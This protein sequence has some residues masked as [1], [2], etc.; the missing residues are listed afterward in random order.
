MKATVR[1]MVLVAILL[2]FGLPNRAVAQ[3]GTIPVG[4]V[5]T[6]QNWQ[7]Y[8]QF[9]PH[10][11]QELAK[12]TYFWKLPPDF[13]LVV[14]PTHHYAPP[15]TFQQY[16][17]KY[18]GLVKIGD[19]P[20]GKHL[21][22][23]YV[24]G[25]PFPNPAEPMKGWKILVNLWYGYTPKILCTPHAHLYFQDRYHNS[26]S[27]AFI[28]VYQKLDHIGDAGFPITDP[29]SNGV[30]Y[31]EYLQITQPEQARYTAQLT[32]YYDDFAKDEDLFL[33]VPALRRSLRLSS[34]AR[35]SPIIGSDYSQDEAKPT[36]FNCTP[37]RFDATYLGSPPLLG[38]TV[39]DPVNYGNINNFYPQVLMPT[40]AVG[41]W[42]VRPTY[43][44]DVRRIPSQQSGYCYSKKILWIDSE[45]YS[46]LWED[47]YDVTGKL[48]KTAYVE[49]IATEV[50][51]E[52]IQG[53]SGHLYSVMYDIQGDH[54]SMYNSS[55]P[56]VK[57]NQDCANYD[58]ENYMNTSRY[59]TVSALS[60]I[61]R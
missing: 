18:S 40:P 12:G 35:C 20:G 52:G 34:A 47:L 8:Q 24:A 39:S 23:G 46:T 49:P 13:Q 33:F 45:I 14:G 26:T 61:M 28:E 19:G 59:A 10:G 7:Q 51:G 43:E 50:N 29:A 53:S 41:K 54:L 6:M 4:T 60:E 22:T 30:Q 31:S 2:A 38:M 48:W 55:D 5:I 15:V 58:G 36:L 17:E 44:L 11:M 25:W 37:S 1:W 21:L 57:T 42:E 9:M 56:P 3:E 16:T 32:L 27:E